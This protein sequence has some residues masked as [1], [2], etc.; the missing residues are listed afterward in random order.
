MVNCIATC[1][2]SF[3]T[4][5]GLDPKICFEKSFAGVV[6]EHFNLPQKVYARG[7]CCNYTIFLQVKKILQQKLENKDLLPLVL[8]T[9]TNHERIIIPTDD[10]TKYVMPDLAN[11]DYMNY[12]PYHPHSGNRPVQFKLKE[13]RLLTQT[14]SNVDLLL[15]TRSGAVKTHFEGVELEKLETLGR[16][17]TDIFDT[18]IKKDYDDSL[19]VFMHLLLKSNNVSHI[20]MGYQLPE[21]I[22]EQN[23]LENMWGYYAGL[24]PDVG[25]SG[26]CN[27][28]G[29]RLVGMNVVEHIEKYSLL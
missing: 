19:F 14:I 12:T 21:V 17:Y 4:G 10:G 3:G 15:K 9:T 11:V 22:D 1:G 8:I 23:R 7:G 28:E 20:I 25:G 18:A 5:S 2:D 13:P 26:H 27:E 29:N 16:Y 24:Y 6:A